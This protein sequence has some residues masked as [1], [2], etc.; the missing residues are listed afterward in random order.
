[1]PGTRSASSKRTTCCLACPHTEGLGQRQPRSPRGQEERYAPLYPG[2]RL[3]S[4]ERRWTFTT[5]PPPLLRCG[6]SIPW[7]GREARR[8]T[9]SASG[10]LRCEPPGPVQTPLKEGDLWWRFIFAE[11]DMRQVR[12]ASHHHPRGDLRRQGEGEGTHGLLRSL[13]DRPDSFQFS[14]RRISLDENDVVKNLD[15]HS[16]FFGFDQNHTQNLGGYAFRIRTGWE[17]WARTSLIKMTHR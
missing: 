16:D 13:A 17:L 6:C 4:E 14:S 7:G 5:S 2:G 9:D 8:R 1:M 3:S 10:W 11:S 15:S 12:C